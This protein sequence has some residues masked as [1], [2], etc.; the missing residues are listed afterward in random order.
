MIHVEIRNSRGDIN[1]L[2]KSLTAVEAIQLLRNAI[3]EIRAF[4]L[5]TF[6]PS[7]GEQPR[8]LIAPSDEEMA[9]LRGQTTVN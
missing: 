3:E 5:H 7:F 9:A 8:A 1:L 6:D 4:S 2:E